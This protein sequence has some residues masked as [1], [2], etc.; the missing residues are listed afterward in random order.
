MQG[1]DVEIKLYKPLN[2]SKQFEGELVGLTEENNIKVII[3]NEDEFKKGR[4]TYK[5]CNKVLIKIDWGR[6]KNESRIYRSIR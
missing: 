3:N 4:C 6:K 1:R 5:T 2:G